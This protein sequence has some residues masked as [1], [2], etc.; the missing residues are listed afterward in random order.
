MHTE[1][2]MA[3]SDLAG[4]LQREL[5]EF[6]ED[7]WEKNVIERLSFQQQR[8]IEEKRLASL[9]ELDLAAL[10]RVLDQ[11]WFELSQ[12][13]KFPREGRNWVKEL[14]TVRNKWAHAPADDAPPSEIYRDA[15]T[16]E[17]LLSLINASKASIEAATVMKNAALA[18]MSKASKTASEDEREA[19]DTLS[20]PTIEKP[21]HLFN[22]GELVTLRSDNSVKV[23]V[24]EVVFGGPEIRYRVFQDGAK[25]TYYESQLQAIGGGDDEKPE[26]SIEEF[27]ARLT[28]QH[29]LSPSTANLFSLRSGRVNFVPYQYRPVLKLIRSDRPRL[30]IADE[31]GVGKT[32]EAGLVIKELSARTD[33]SSILVICPK[34]LVAE[35]KWQT[36]MKRFDQDFTHL[37]GKLLRHCLQETDLEGEWPEKYGKSIL[38]FSLFDS[39]LIFGQGG[40]KQKKDRGLLA[41]DPAP[42]FD[43]VIV[44]EA[45]HIRNADTFLHQGVRY[46]CDN[47]KAVLLMTATPVQLGSSDL[48]TLL[49]VVRP[50]LVIDEASFEQMAAPN[51][52]I[53]EA[54]RLCREKSAGWQKDA[55]DQ[56][57][58]AAQTEWGRLFLR[59]EA[60]FQGA[61]DKLQEAEIPDSERVLMTRTLEELYTFSSIINRTRRR[62]IGEFTMRKPQTLTVDFNDEQRDLH[63]TLLNIIAKILVRCHGQQNVK[64]MMTTI[65]RQAASCLFG[66]AP[67]LSDILTRK[68][69]QLEVIESNDI[70]DEIDLSFVDQVR[71]EIEELLHKAE[72]LSPDDAKVEAFIRALKEK[73]SLENNKALVFSTFR[74]TLAYLAKHAEAAGLRFGLVHGDVTDEERAELRRRFALPKAD[75]NA[76]DVLLSSEVGCEG[77]DFQFCDFLVNYDLPWNPMRIEQ[78]IGRIDRYGQKSEAVSIVNLV[79]PGTVDADIYQRCLWRIGVFHHAVGGGEEILGEITQEIHDIAE[80]FVLTEDEREKKLQQLADNGIRRIREEQD[81]EEK[82]VEL[83]GLNVPKQSWRED[84]EDAESEWLSTASIKRCVSRYLQSKTGSDADPLSGDKPLRTL[85]VSQ[86]VRNALLA[87]FRKFKRSNDALSRSWEK[88]LKG[89]TPSLTVTFDQDAAA[90][91]PSTVHLTVMH[92]LVRQAARFLEMDEAMYCSLEV[93]DGLPPGQHK[94]AL[95]RWTMHGIKPDEQL[96]AVATDPLVESAL[97]RVLHRAVEPILS[98]SQS[99][100]DF[101]DLDNLHHTKW[102]AAQANHI[103]ENQKLAEHR[104]QSLTV[105]HRARVRI[106]D[107]QISKATNDRIRRMKEA[108]LARANGD[109][110]RRVSELRDAGNTG[111]IRAAPIMLGTI[112]VRSGT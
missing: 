12:K 40:R 91:N 61:F 26:I 2:R 85:R 8:I 15:D 66:L 41:L 39:D 68:L 33:I 44:D 19:S 86:E 108:E 82:E 79:T 37:D 29:L 104:V 27:K 42:A 47:A 97:L 62:D 28:A 65:R 31:V 43:L 96:V 80:S 89:G 92:P 32:I 112:S 22:V 36:E 59:E 53:N 25:S 72:N 107:D 67:L 69:D 46:F 93:S 105:S 57:R 9:R 110:E 54:V 83:F 56:L 49:N 30:L 55:S 81:L 76:L 50:D 16:L 95:Y 51:R 111:D 101:D 70:D 73:A 90:E 38:P 94:F 109:F 18:S 11:N 78:R 3:S 106:L 4:F 1:L 64:F 5:P 84:I 35:R 20:E 99:A 60:N 98:V 21:T 102:S 58:E 75:E 6:S 7:W 17:R 48:F 23:P 52:F 74:H 14:Q 63:D 24:L 13:L 34:A 77:L 71:A 45:H 100:E 10:L 88:W 87:D 103:A